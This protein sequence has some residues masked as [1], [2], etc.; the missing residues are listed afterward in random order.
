MKIRS[1]LFGFLILG[2]L[3]A[4]PV[5]GADFEQAEEYTLERGFVIFD[6]L[7]VAGGSVIISGDIREDL[8]A[9]GGKVLVNGRVNGDIFASG[10]TVDILGRVADDVR[11]A[12]GQIVIGENVL[13]DIIAAGGTV[14]ILPNVIVRGDVIVAGGRV[15]VGGTIDKDLKVFGGEVVLNGTVV[16]NVDATLSKSLEIGDNA[17]VGGFLLYRAPEEAVISDSA[18]ITGEITFEE[19]VTR[20]QFEVV[21]VLVSLYGLLLLLKL[22]MFVGTGVAAVILF[23]NFSSTVV[24]NSVSKFGKNLLYGFIVFIIVPIAIAVLF[25]TVLGAVIGLLTAV[26]YI[27]LIILAKIFAG[28]VVGALLSKAITKEVIVKWYWAVFG[29]VVLQVFGLI[30]IVGQLAIAVFCLVA[31]GA[32]WQLAYQ[33]FWLSR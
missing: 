12:G 11:V 15:I 22:L 1:F 18:I 16:G 23:K 20:G 24:R 19:R 4:L 25:A 31:L 21:T 29:I 13:G 5:F 3:A 28:I 17:R 10:G 2:V 14:Q 27:A 26:L 9:A 6:D 7:Y 32:I 8:I 30:P 33:R